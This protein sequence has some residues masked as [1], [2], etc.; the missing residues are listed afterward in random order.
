M[1]VWHEHMCPQCFRTWECGADGCNPEWDRFC[2]YGE[3]CHVRSDGVWQVSPAT[4]RKGRG[5]GPLFDTRGVPVVS[6]YQKGHQ[7]RV[8]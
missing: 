4:I 6:P 1:V 5:V 8:A 7:G 2:P 3:L